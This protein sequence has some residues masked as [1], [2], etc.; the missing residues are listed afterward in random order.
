MGQ[1]LSLSES[2]HKALKDLDPETLLTNPKRQEEL[3]S[4][5]SGLQYL[6]LE[7]KFTDEA[8]I[9]NHPANG[10]NFCIPYDQA[11]T[12]QIHRDLFVELRSCF[13]NFSDRHLAIIF[14]P[15]RQ[16]DTLFTSFRTFLPLCANIDKLRSL[17]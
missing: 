7:L 14:Q 12:E 9:C 1:K 11:N 13:G 10:F 16:I 6:G 4:H 3:E 5:W 8:L 2:L 17:Q 15:S